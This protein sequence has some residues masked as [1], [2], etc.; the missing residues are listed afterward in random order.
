MAYQVIAR[1]WRPQTYSEIVHQDHVSRTLQNSIKSGRIPHAYI[2]SGP[3]GVGKTTTARVLAKSLNC[4]NGPTPEPCGVCENCR[5]ITD[6]TSFDV[7]E[8]DGASNNGV[9]NIRELCEKVNFAPVKSKYKI[10]VIDEVHMLSGSAFNALLKTLEEPPAHAVFILATTEEHKIPET[11]LSRCQKYRFR[12]IST[13][14][15]VG[16]LKH[17]IEKDERTL[18]EHELYA[19]ARIAGGSMRDAQSLLEQV[20]AF[21]EGEDLFELIGIVP[22]QSFIRVL[23]AIVENNPPAI[24]N[25]CRHI[26][27]AGTNISRYTE[28]FKDILRAMRLALFQVPFAEIA[29]YSPE[30]AREIGSCAARFNDEELS[31]F[32]ELLQ[33]LSH[34]LRYT[35]AEAINLEMTLLDMLSLHGAPT[36]A[37]LL[38]KIESSSTESIEKKKSGETV[39]TPKPY[40]P[41]P[42][43]PETKSDAGPLIE[44]TWKKILVRTGLVKKYL[45]KKLERCTFVYRTSQVIIVPDE[46]TPA[47]DGQDTAWLSGQLSEVIS[48]ASAVLQKREHKA[49]VPL[50]RDNS[51]EEKAPLPT[52]QIKAALDEE[53]DVPPLVKKVVDMFHGEIV[54]K[55][56]DNSNA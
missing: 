47:I 13:D 9:D 30:E 25:E 3:R 46:D 45:S 35:D 50:A 33:K 49:D 10:Y 28:A 1:R 53:I 18:A 55:E 24:V 56:G 42:S 29:G 54:T 17:I 39:E 26:S 48:G 44:E 19:I 38:Q 20:L 7:I 4:V 16:Q 22:V 41:P 23:S 5:E 51:A 36:I 43:P 12:R 8:I 27:D 37:A 6:G 40:F 14:G 31:R 34:D 2:F 52:Q 21:P 11:I 32:F 15:I